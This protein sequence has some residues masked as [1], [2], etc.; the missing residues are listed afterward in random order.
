LS[1]REHLLD[2]AG[3][4]G[5]YACSL[6][7][8]FS[9][10]RATVLE[11]PPVDQVTKRAIAKRGLSREVSVLASDM[12]SDA[13]PE[14]FDVHLLSN[15]LHDWDVQMVK[16][17]LR[18]SFDALTPGGMLIIHD[19]HLKENKTGPIHVAE[20]SVMLVHSTQGRC[21]SVKEMTEYLGE[22]GFTEIKFMPTVAARSVFTAR[23]QR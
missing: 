15:V 11:K 16:R 2:I 19:A 17:L 12:I 18:K 21:Y 5:I 7:A 8:H 4:S 23:K 13:L 3:G 22:E 14:G 9:N 20:Y 6:C 1:R 10:L